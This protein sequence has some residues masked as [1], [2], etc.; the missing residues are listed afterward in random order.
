M[1]MVECTYERGD[2]DVQDSALWVFLFGT[3]RLLY[4]IS[5]VSVQFQSFKVSFNPEIWEIR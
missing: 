2:F 5:S 1:L 4:G 3:S